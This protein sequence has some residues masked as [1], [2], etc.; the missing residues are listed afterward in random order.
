MTMGEDA[1]NDP[2]LLGEWFALAWTG[3][4]APGKLV[5]RK[6]LGRD[7]VLWRSAQGIHC[8]HDLCI[9]RG[10]KLSLGQVC[11]DRVVC[12]YHAWEYGSSGQCE[13]I[14]SHPDQPPPLKARAQTYHAQERYGMV[15]VCVGEPAADLPPFALGDDAAFRLML[16]GP[17]Y[18]KAL[19][20]RVV[21]NFLDVAHLGFVHAGL[22]GDPQHG[23]IEDY[24]V[25]MGEHGP[26]AHAIRIWQPDPDGT[27]Q[28]AQVTYH[29]WVAAPLTVGL[30]KDH[31][32]QRFG[33]LMQVAPVDADT[34]AARIV[35]AVDYAPDVPDQTFIG[36]QDIVA[37]QDKVIVESQR[38]EL[39]PLDLQAELHLRSDRMAIAYRKWL[40]SIG[41]SYGTA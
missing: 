24:E 31:N 2:K 1:L 40:R 15:W 34:C 11:N 28:G 6:L 16:A 20:P 13:H 7:V 8:W 37:A 19:G 21:E 22:L 12:P 26:E 9:H 27:G 25:A 39:L 17:Y 33:L 35:I 41:F 30:M 5:A 3:E 38:P 14:P 29:Y 18:F 32:R 36:Y 23:E 10:A 4:V